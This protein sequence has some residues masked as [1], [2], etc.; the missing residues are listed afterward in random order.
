M[1][2]LRRRLESVLNDAAQPY[3]A[4]PARSDF[5]LNPKWRERMSPAELTPAAVLVPIMSRNCDP[6]ILFTQRTPHLKAH[7]GQVSFPG[8]RMETYDAGPIAAALRESKEEVGLDPE[9]VD[10]V[11][12]LDNYQT[13]TNYLVT[14]VVGIV[15][16]EF[17]P[18]R[19][20]SEVAQIFEVPLGHVLD[21]SQF[22][23]ET[24]DVGEFTRVFYAMYYEDWRIWGATAGMLFDLVKRMAQD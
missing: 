13:G 14:P 19:D 3:L 2:E 21:Q 22:I 10:V 15:H 8:G 5:D 9:Y 17:E 16:P 11:G 4:E 18:I 6:S 7:G 20:T 24:R 23:H 12:L 1:R